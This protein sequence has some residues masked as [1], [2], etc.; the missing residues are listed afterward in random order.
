MNEKVYD[1]SI[2]KLCISYLTNRRQRVIHKLTNTIS[3]E[4][5]SNVGVPQGARCGPKLWNLFI[6]TLDMETDIIK[7][8]DD[9]TIFT[10]IPK[11]TAQTTGRNAKS[12]PDQTI[13]TAAQISANWCTRNSMTINT[14]KT[15]HMLLTLKNE[16]SL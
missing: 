8:A 10:S 1:Q 6:S 7:Y 12:T 4:R 15:K 11:S 14:S 5:V 3:S 9:V 16:V 13:A 2:I